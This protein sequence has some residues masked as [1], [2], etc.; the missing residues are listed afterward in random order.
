MLQYAKSKVYFL[1]VRA[2]VTSCQRGE[3]G[4]LILAPMIGRKKAD[5]AAEATEDAKQSQAQLYAFHEAS[6]R[7]PCP[8]S[9]RMQSIIW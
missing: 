4:I 3:K 2:G 6:K 7:V 8:Q 1:L 9:R 5:G